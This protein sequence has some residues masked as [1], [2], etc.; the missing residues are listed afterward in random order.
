MEA[1]LAER[2]AELAQC[3]GQL[4]RTEQLL[5]KA[6][7]AAAKQASADAAWAQPKA[8]SPAAKPAAQEDFSFAAGCNTT[9][10]TCSVVRDCCRG[11]DCYRVRLG[12]QSLAYFLMHMDSAF[13]EPLIPFLGVAFHSRISAFVVQRV[14]WC[15]GGRLSLEEDG[16]GRH[17]QRS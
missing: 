14:V 8:A 10:S 4:H 2:E 12:L 11:W 16:C 6:R 7:Q 3:R 17:L 15:S 1:Q 5:E 9:L 13:A